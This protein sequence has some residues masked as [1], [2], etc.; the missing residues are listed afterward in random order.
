[1]DQI[2]DFLGRPN[3]KKK[4]KEKN[5]GLGPP[6]P[7]YEMAQLTKPFLFWRGTSGALSQPKDSVQVIQNNGEGARSHGEF[8]ISI[9]GWFLYS[10][11]WLQDAGAT[12]ERYLAS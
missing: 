11:S 9:S 4:K 7:N 12:S 5:V 3:R 10:F 6:N 8:T 2:R 1:M